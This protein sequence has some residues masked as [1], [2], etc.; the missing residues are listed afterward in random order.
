MKFFVTRSK[1]LPV[2]AATGNLTP[3]GQAI[4]ESITNARNAAIGYNRSESWKV[5]LTALFAA[6]IS[7]LG[8]IQAIYEDRL[9]ANTKKSFGFAQ[10]LLP[11]LSVFLL[12]II[13]T[14][15]GTKRGIV[16]SEQ[17]AY[18]KYI[19]VSVEDNTVNSQQPNP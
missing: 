19:R 6:A 5:I 10:L 7:I 8:G 1:I 14:L 12:A 3:E 16:N 18:P 15:Q 11:I 2:D 4:Q 13:N 17:R 9:S